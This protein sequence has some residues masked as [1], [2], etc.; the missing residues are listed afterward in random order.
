MVVIVKLATPLTAVELRPVKV[1]PLGA[2][3][4]VSLEL[5][6]ATLP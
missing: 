1:P 4:T 2:K 6:V 3:V 5:F